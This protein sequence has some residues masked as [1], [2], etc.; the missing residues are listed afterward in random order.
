MQHFTHP[1]KGTYTHTHTHT[2]T[3]T[4]VRLHENIFFLMKSHF[5]EHTKKMF[6]IFLIRMSENVNITNTALLFESNRLFLLSK[7][8]GYR[9]NILGSIL[10]Q[11]KSWSKKKFSKFNL[12]NIFAKLISYEF[13]AIL[14]ASFLFNSSWKDLF[15]IDWMIKS[16]IPP[17][18]LNKLC[19]WRFKRSIV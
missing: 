5:F 11:I 9:A 14:F 12:Q 19:E 3:Y 2:Q 7:I 18:G 4:W 13:S 1:H 10:C 6:S 17:T 8:T 15:L 16:T